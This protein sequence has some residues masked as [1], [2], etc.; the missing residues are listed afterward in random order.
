MNPTVFLDVDEAMRCDR[1]QGLLPF[2]TTCMSKRHALTIENVDGAPRTLI[3]PNLILSKVI[4]SNLGPG[5]P[6]GP[7]N[8]T[9]HSQPTHWETCPFLEVLVGPS[10]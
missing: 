3:T 5:V 1:L 2:L 7:W 10:T 4:A 8:H 6:G 9:L